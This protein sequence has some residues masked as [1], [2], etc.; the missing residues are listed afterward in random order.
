MERFQEER[1]V[2]NSFQLQNSNMVSSNQSHSGT[3]TLIS[4]LT[5]AVSVAAM[6]IQSLGDGGKPASRSVLGTRSLG[7]Q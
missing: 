5:H 6:S 7:T 2:S 3:S 4:A 1:G